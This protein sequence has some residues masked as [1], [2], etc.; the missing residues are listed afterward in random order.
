MRQFDY[1]KRLEALPSVNF[2]N[3][4][5][6]TNFIESPAFKYVCH[7]QFFFQFQTEISQREKIS[8]MRSD[9]NNRNRIF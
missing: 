2:T 9:E 6:Y 8:S 7:K 3:F 4:F 5:Q 1:A